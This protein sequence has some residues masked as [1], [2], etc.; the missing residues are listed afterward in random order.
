MRRAR[1]PTDII[2]SMGRPPRSLRRRFLLPGLAAG[3]AE[4]SAAESRHLAIVLRA[5][6]GEEIEV[7][8]GRGANGRARVLRVEPSRVTL[9]VISV[10]A[11]P[12]GA[13]AGLAA[14]IPRGARG[15][16]MIEK[17]TEAGMDV[18]FPLLTERGVATAE[19]AAKRERWERI[20]A[21]ASKQCGRPTLPELLE[22]RPLAQVVEETA[23]WPVRFLADV[24][25]EAQPAPEGDA[26]VFVGPEGGWTAAERRLLGRIPAVRLGPHVLR[27]E[28]AAVLGVAWIRSRV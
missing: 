15:D 11:R 14:A 24:S 25:G 13:R 9:E 26:L 1:R 2:G 8:D 18:F 3:G 20:A 21:E 6:A 16:W 7:F 27:I 28:T 22:P 19:G 10:V 17:A 12:A 5:A 4:L 23:A